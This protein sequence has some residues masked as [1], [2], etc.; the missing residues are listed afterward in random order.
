M[1]I[2]PTYNAIAEIPSKAILCCWYACCCYSPLWPVT[3]IVKN[4]IWS[5]LHAFVARSIIKK[6]I[7]AGWNTFHSTPIIFIS[8]IT[9]GYIINASLAWTIVK[10]ASKTIVN[11][12]YAR[13]IFTRLKT[14]TEIPR[15]A[16][17]SIQNTCCVESYGGTVTKKWISAVCCVR[18]AFSCSIVKIICIT[19]CSW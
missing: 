13:S 4:A 3:K 17:F 16:L 14:V 9:I 5:T 8:R 19:V 11:W 15:K 2:R 10:I 1:S 18:N 6:R 7:R 12:F